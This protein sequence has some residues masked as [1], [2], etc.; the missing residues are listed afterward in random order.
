MTT[1]APPAPG[2]FED[3]DAGYAPAAPSGA[4]AAEIEAERRARQDAEARV[5]ALERRIGEF[6][7]ALHPTRSGGGSM[8]SYGGDDGA[9]E[10]LAAELRASTGGEVE[11][12]GGVVI[13][14]MC[15]SFRAGSEQLKQDPALNTTL[16]ATAEALMR[17]PTARV[18]VVGHSDGQP[19]NRTKDRWRDNVH[20]SR[21]RAQTVATTLA[22]HGVPASRIE[23]DGR[24]SVEPLAYPERTDTDRARNRRVEVH[25]R[26]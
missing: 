17:Y 18:A 26:F 2:G 9:A 16:M 12:N 21:E 14:R 5:N 15:D 23:V 24:G 11:Q 7:S 10:R 3:A 6:E 4:I 19:I 25:I 1:W 20:L 22:R 8:P 13:V